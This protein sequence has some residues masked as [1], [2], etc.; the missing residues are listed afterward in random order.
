MSRL[1]PIVATAAA[2]M[3]PEVF[4]SARAA[5]TAGADRVE[6]RLDLLAPGENPRELF[7][8]AAEMPLLVSGRRD[9][10]C[11]EELP[12]LQEAQARGAWVDVPVQDAPGEALSALIPERLVISSHD[13]EETPQ[14]LA[15]RTRSL[16]RIPAAARKIVTTADNLKECLRMRELLAATPSESHLAAFAMGQA[17]LL[18]RAL[19]LAWGSEAVYASAPHSPSA[20]P[21][22]APLEDLLCWAPFSIT[23]ATPLF[24]LAGWPLDFT[25]TPRFFNRWLREAGRE[26]RYLPCPVESIGEF[27]SLL[28][29][30]PVAGAAVTI[31]HKE[32]IAAQL[33]GL[34][35]LASATG[36]VNTLLKMKGGGWSGA[37][38]DVWGIRSALSALPKRGLRT[39]I[40]GAGG[41]AAAAIYALRRRGPVAL[42]S[43]NP[44]RSESLANPLGIE[45]VPWER[46]GEP[47]WDLLVNAT[48]LGRK[49]E[50]MPLAEHLL[51]GGT[52]FDMV[53]RREG[54][55]PLLQA[56]RRMGLEA[57]PGEAMLAAQARL[58]FRLWTGRRPP[59]YIDT[60]HTS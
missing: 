45:A 24:L 2:P 8:L 7:A 14:D 25:Q 38:T 1:G 52:V 3:L 32:G 39:L 48:P 31:P 35:R 30:L 23:H 49:G 6:V 10:F 57:I 20:A 37:N 16:L 26:E 46:R 4:R 51:R 27:V 59:I 5:R 22:Q 60:K 36:A 50:E 56:A 19:G 55:T 33:Q 12:L 44:S 41:A 34:S 13:F 28:P 18:S 47:Q 21:G 42:S 43:R 54:E 11:P 9:R 17:G 15:G 29:S 53:V 58:Q 40:L